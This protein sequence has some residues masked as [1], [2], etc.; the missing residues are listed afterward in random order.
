MK[1]NLIEG[2]SKS[3]DSTEWLSILVSVTHIS[4][5]PSIAPLIFAECIELKIFQGKRSRLV[6]L[7]SKAAY[8]LAYELIE[9]ASAVEVNMAEDSAYY[10][11]IGRG[12]DEGLRDGRIEKRKGKKKL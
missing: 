5:D 3:L 2:R 7:Q 1:M 11:G 10:K 8:Q 12:Y 9:N 4:G 6:Q